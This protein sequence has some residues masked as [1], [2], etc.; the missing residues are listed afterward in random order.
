[1]SGNI[2]LYFS[3]NGRLAALHLLDSPFGRRLEQVAYAVEDDGTVLHIEIEEHPPLSS[4]ELVL[5]SL[6]DA[7]SHG[8]SDFRLFG[9]LDRLDDP[10]WDRF[11]GALFIARGRRML[12][13]VS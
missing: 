5:F 10:N 7:L 8:G 6:L 12:V 13:R 3:D 9:D 11:I 2:D 4:G 1:M